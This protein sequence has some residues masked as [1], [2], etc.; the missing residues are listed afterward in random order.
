MGTAAE[1]APP[2]APVPVLPMSDMD[3]TIKALGQITSSFRIWE[4]DWKLAPGMID[5]L[6]ML[7]EERLSRRAARDR[8]IDPTVIAS[9]SDALVFGATVDGVSIAVRTSSV[10]DVKAA[11]A[12]MQL[13]LRRRSANF[14]LVR[15]IYPV[16]VTVRE[17]ARG[18]T[19]T[20]EEVGDRAHSAFFIEMERIDGTFLQLKCDGCRGSR[21][22]TGAHDKVS[23]HLAFEHVWFEYVATMMLGTSPTD[24]ALRNMAF[25][26]V[27]YARAYHILK[28]VIVMPP[29]TKMFKRIDLG[30][31]EGER[32][33]SHTGM[34]GGV[35]REWRSLQ[36]LDL[37]PV[38]GNAPGKFVHMSN[39][40]DGVRIVPGM[41]DPGVWAF[42]EDVKKRDAM[43]KLGTIGELASV[44]ATAE[45]V[46]GIRVLGGDTPNAEIEKMWPGKEVRHYYF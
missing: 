8:Y 7:C 18:R 17:P 34:G 33:G 28:H 6:S 5:E 26:T 35:R 15:A 4:R 11:I 21:S 10:A 14:A 25:L 42:Y 12:V 3:V 41:C 32:Y 27:P 45:G 39:A 22:C 24:R 19:V 44:L 16:G 38:G 46:G 40:W 9:G 43:G 30:F 13:A 29:D 1:E 36:Y 31:Q 2:L 37:K 23:M 20:F